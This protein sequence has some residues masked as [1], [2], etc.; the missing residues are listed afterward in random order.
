MEATSYQE[1]QAYPQGCLDSCMVEKGV[2]VLPIVFG[3]WLLALVTG[4]LEGSESG[5]D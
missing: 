3:S 5:K 2:Q 1:K 4:W